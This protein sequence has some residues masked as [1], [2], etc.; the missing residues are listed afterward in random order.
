MWQI[1]LAHWQTAKETDAE[2]QALE[3]VVA[4]LVV[5]DACARA[6]ACV[7]VYLLNLQCESPDTSC[8]LWKGKIQNSESKN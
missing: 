8:R 6:R 4:T 1:I 5:S 2:A 7:S 3:H